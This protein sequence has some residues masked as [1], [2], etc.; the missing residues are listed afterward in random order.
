MSACDH[1]F[2]IRRWN[3]IS[4]GR[5]TITSPGLQIIT[6]S[7]KWKYGWKHAW[8]GSENLL[9]KKIQHLLKYNTFT[10]S[11]SAIFTHAQA[12]PLHI[13]LRW[14]P[15]IINFTTLG[16][17]DDTVVIPAISSH[18]WLSESA[19][20]MFMSILNILI[21]DVKSNNRSRAKLR[22]NPAGFTPIRRDT[23]TFGAAACGIISSCI[24][25]FY[26]FSC[27]FSVKQINPGWGLWF[28]LGCTQACNV[29]AADASAD[30]SRVCALSCE[31]LQQ[32]RYM[33]EFDLH[34][35][36]P[37][38]CWTYFQTASA[39]TSPRYFLHVCLVLLSGFG[40]TPPPQFSS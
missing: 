18:S 5:K 20:L 17:W 1:V 4:S 36:T 14:L 40:D 12:A 35:S 37:A 39:G 24:S 2:S 9:L 29:W 33:R 19:F 11:K 8:G 38:S 16:M 25:T 31:L 30:I 3:E 27:W 7:W 13:Y 28:P 26:T 23:L 21:H 15:P 6:M 10:G 34:Q 32:L 22:L